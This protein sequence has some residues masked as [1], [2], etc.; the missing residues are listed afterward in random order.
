MQDKDSIRS[1]TNWAETAEST[2]SAVS[3]SSF[4]LM[5]YKTGTDFKSWQSKVSLCICDCTSP[6]VFFL[7]T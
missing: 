5:R 6:L 3:S 7:G 1:S 4:F 2:T